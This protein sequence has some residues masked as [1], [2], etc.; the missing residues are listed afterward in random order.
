[1]EALGYGLAIALGIVFIVDRWSAVPTNAVAVNPPAAANTASREAPTTTNPPAVVNV[2]TR[3]P[4]LEASTT[5]ETP[6]AVAQEVEQTVAKAPIRSASCGR[7]M[8]TITGMMIGSMSPSF[9]SAAT[10]R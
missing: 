4:S 10:L 5:T 6:A 1:M 9:G 3:M 7:T 2:T 8:K